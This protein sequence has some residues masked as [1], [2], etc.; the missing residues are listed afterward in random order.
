MLKNL[1]QPANQAYFGL[2]LNDRSIKVVQLKKQSDGLKIVSF[3]RVDVPAGV[4]VCGDIKDAEALVAQLKKS[5]EEVIGESLKTNRCICSLPEKETFLKILQMPKMNDAELGQAVGWEV[6]TN[7]P[8][9]QEQVYFDWEVVESSKNQPDHLDVFFGALPREFAD[10]YLNVLRRAGLKP[11]V[12]EVE[13]SA[14]VR[15]LVKD[16]LAVKPQLI[17]DLGCK[18]SSVTIFSGQAIHFAASLNYCGET[19]DNIISQQLSIDLI[20]AV[21]LKKAIGFDRGAG[22]EK[23][24]EAIAPFVSDLAEQLEKFIKYYEERPRHDHAINESVEKV[25]LT[26][27][28]ANLTGLVGFLSEKLGKTVEKGDPMVNIIAN[29]KIKIPEPDLATYATAMGLAIRGANNY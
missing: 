12:F 24:A 28:G 21:R 29:E 15:A 25:I 14:I 6:E 8:M 5:V 17:A 20:E 10:S 26:G 3:N 18:R 27:G 19:L 23:V 22:N 9:S 13:L 7:I 11:L 1:L 16:C 4:I 2:D